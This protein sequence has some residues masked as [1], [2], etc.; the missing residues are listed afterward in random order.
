[1]SHRLGMDK[2]PEDDSA[3]KK[4]GLHLMMQGFLLGSLPKA[5]S[6]FPGAKFVA[7]DQA[8]LFTGSERWSARFSRGPFPVTRA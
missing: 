3:N 4:V 1:M 7:Y 5:Y 8:L 6:H 2:A